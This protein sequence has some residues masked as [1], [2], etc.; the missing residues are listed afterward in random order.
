M[1]LTGQLI[2][3]GKPVTLLQPQSV[4]NSA[5]TTLWVSFRNW[6]RLQ[7]VILIGANAGTS[8]NH[9]AVTLKQAQDS[10][11]TGSKAL[12]FDQYYVG[13]ISQSLDTLTATTVTND[14][15]NVIAG[16]ANQIY[17]IELLDTQLDL[18]NGFQWV[19]VNLAAS[20]EAAAILM[21]VFGNFYGGDYAGKPSTLPSVVAPS[22][23]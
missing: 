8:T 9:V 22:P 18:N 1:I 13:T 6:K 16:T 5:K 17:L 21:A 20:G 7:I 2:E 3:N 19:Q 14:T 11:G 15:F 12:S 10:S 23:V 4:S